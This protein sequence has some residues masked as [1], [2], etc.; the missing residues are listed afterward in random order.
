MGRKTGFW[1]GI[2][3][4][5]SHSLHTKHRTHFWVRTVPVEIL[6]VGY[7]VSEGNEW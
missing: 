7:L 2:F 4:V 3:F 1:R 6:D 5:W